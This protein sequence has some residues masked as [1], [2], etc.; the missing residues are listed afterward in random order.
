MSLASQRNTAQNL[1]L[2]RELC[3]IAGSFQRAG[4]PLLVLKGVPLTRRLH[5]DLGK[6]YSV[7]ND[8]LVRRADVP[9]AERL[10]TEL[11]YAASPGRQLAVDLASTFQ[12]PMR[13]GLADGALL[14]AELHWQAFPPELFAVPEEELWRHA[15]Q[16][17]SG[18]QELL[19]FDPLMTLLHLASH[20]VQHRCAEAKVLDDVGAAWRRYAAEVDTRELARLA[21][22]FGLTGALAFSLDAAYRAGSCDA[23]SPI[24]SRRAQLLGRWLPPA[25]HAAE[26]SYG[27]ILGSLLL[28]SPRKISGA[29]LRELFPP[30]A[31]L[32]RVYGVDPSPSL[33]FRYPLRLL[34]PAKRWLSLPRSARR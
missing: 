7:D 28:A 9:R 3:Q 29:L 27:S 19:V 18:E 30:P 16:Y 22:R 15:T 2:E 21:A 24:T 34:R 5:G 25:T 33:L 10:L 6:R 17:F 32:A 26:P 31:I 11:G 1:L 12:H 4:V 8:L 14:R 20:H 23:P 13:R